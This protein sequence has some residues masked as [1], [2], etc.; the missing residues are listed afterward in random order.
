MGILGP[1]GDFIIYMQLTAL[2]SRVKM[3]VLLVPGLW[4]LHGAKQ[5]LWVF[6]V[7]S[8]LSVGQLNHGKLPACF[9]RTTCLRIRSFRTGNQAGAR[10]RS[11]DL[12]IGNKRSATNGKIR[13]VLVC[14]NHCKRSNSFCHSFDL[15]DESGNLYW[16]CFFR[17][18][19]QRMSEPFKNKFLFPLF[20]THNII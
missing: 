17:G 9:A 20:W 16:Q 4:P 1:R 11:F 13:T 3:H 18:H 10:V 6:V 7:T 14:K 8:V 2:R 12:A 19:S 5:H 15:I